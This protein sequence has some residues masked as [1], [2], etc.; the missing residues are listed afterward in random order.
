MKSIAVIGLSSFGHYLCRYLNEI[1]TSVLAIDISEERINKVKPYVRKAVVADAGGKE[2]LKKLG[3]EEFDEVVISVGEEIDTSVLIT[4]YLRELGVKEIIAKAIT[5]NHAKI[6]NMIGASQ[7]VFPE[8]DIAER[9]AYTMHRSNLLEYFPLG[10]GY[11][12]IEVT[13]PKSWVGKTLMEL[14]VRRK[15]SIQIVMIKQMVPS[16]IILIPDGDFIVK[17]SDVLVVAG[18]DDDLESIEKL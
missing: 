10:E 1:S 13:V 6:L 16:S 3:L 7:I 2:V 18:K 17:D 4:L 14:Q 15:Y 12:I 8:K 5:E 9:M 11:S